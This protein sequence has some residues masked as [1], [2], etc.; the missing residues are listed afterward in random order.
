MS[1]QERPRKEREE[2]KKE[3]SSLDWLDSDVTPTQKQ[4]EV[5]IKQETST[6]TEVDEQQKLMQLFKNLKKK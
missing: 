5:A 6:T 1:T 4:P 3:S 2:T